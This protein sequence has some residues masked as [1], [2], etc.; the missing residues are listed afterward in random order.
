MPS[1]RQQLPPLDALVMFDAAARHMSFTLAADELNITQ[2]AV[3]RQIRLLEEDLGIR[4]FVRAHRN[5]ELTPE[6]RAFQHSV[7]NALVHICDATNE[8]RHVPQ[9]NVVVAV[10]QA[11]AGLWLTPRIADFLARC[12]EL[13]IRIIASDSQV[14]CL[15]ERVDIAIAHGNGYWPGY[16]PKLLF[17]EEVFPVCSPSFLERFGRISEPR[18]LVD[19]PLIENE[20][21]RWD[22]MNWRAWLTAN[23]IELPHKHHKLLINNY[24]FVIRAAEAGHG[25]ALGWRYLIDDSLRAGRLVRPIKNTMKTNLGYYLLTRDKEQTSSAVNAFADWIF[26]AHQANILDISDALVPAKRKR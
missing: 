9:A 3:S 19:L 23:K 5:V 20:D 8:I 7:H 26:E 1:I 21:E 4:L 17:P 14:E 6:G 16:T 10:D 25:V 12:P 24:A 18:A 13:S 15:K 2:A 11:V 22:W